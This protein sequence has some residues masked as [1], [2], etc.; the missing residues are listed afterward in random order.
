VFC[1]D[2]IVCA[3]RFESVG[4]PMA[5]WWGRQNGSAP[6]R[7]TPRQAELLGYIHAYAKWHGRPPAEHEICSRLSLTPPSV[8]DAIMRMEKAGLIARVPRQPRSIR[9]LVPE[10]DIPPFDDGRK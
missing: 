8:L 6:V 4:I 3:K 10:R 5:D 9:I 2:D 1:D 7:M